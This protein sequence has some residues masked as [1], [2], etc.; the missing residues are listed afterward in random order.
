MIRESDRDV[1]DSIRALGYFKLARDYYGS[2]SDFNDRMKDIVQILKGHQSYGLKFLVAV[3]IE[4]S[5]ASPASQ[6]DLLEKIAKKMRE[7]LN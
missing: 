2:S 4:A 1:E 7:D 5:I 3:A 6:P